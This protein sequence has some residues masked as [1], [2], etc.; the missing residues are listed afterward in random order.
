MTDRMPRG[1]SHVPTPAENLRLSLKSAA[2]QFAKLQ[3]Q[4][5]FISRCFID[6]SMAD[7]EHTALRALQERIGDEEI[8]LMHNFLDELV[9]D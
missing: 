8:A 9:R 5:E 2:E 7:E 1:P 3:A 4:K 6:M